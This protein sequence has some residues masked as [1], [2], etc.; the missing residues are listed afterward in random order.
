MADD[1]PA[2]LAHLPLPTVI[3]EISYGVRLAQYQRR[4]VDGFAAVGVDYDVDGLE[5]DPA[6]VQAQVATYKDVLARQRVNEGVRAHHL[7]FAR[8]TDIDHMAHFYDLVRLTGETDNAL[9]RRIVVAIRGRSTGGTEAR[10]KSIALG[11][12]VRVAD[13]AVYTVGRDPTVRVAIFSTAPDGTAGADLVAAVNAALQ[14]PAVRMVNDRI[15]VSPAVR[16]IVNLSAD[17]WLLPEAAET[18]LEQAEANLR[19]RWSS[20]LGLGR[21]V[22]RAW[23]TAQLMIAGVHKVEIGAPLADVIIPFDRAAAIG[24][25]TL[26]NR[27]RLF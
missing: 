22:T 5:T 15:V 3:E 14:D 13:A 6:Q 21:D 2:E 27:G 19:T 9:K 4:L 12:D 17:I 24:T 11:A 10:Y 23:F 26:T 1:I 7:A 16:T 20:T 25:V 18:T 8:G